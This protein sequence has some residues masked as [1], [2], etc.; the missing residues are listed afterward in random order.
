MV[1]RA[2]GLTDPAVHYHFPS[3]QALYLAVLSQPDY[4]PLPLDHA[5]VSRGTVINQLLHIANWWFAHADLGQMVLRGQ[6]SSETPALQY[7]AASEAQWDD[8]VTRPLGELCGEAAAEVSNLVS[9]LLWGIY[10]DAILS[11][12][13]G[14]SQ[15]AAQEYFQDR[16]RQMLEMALP[17]WP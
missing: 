6:L 12:G 16:L 14:A 5:P 9:D 1:A 2:L 15:V 11:F 13:E 8:L 17:E 3:K 4:G 10:S 7:L